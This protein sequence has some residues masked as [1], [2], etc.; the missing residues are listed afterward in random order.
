[1]QLMAERGLEHR[2]TPGFGWIKGEIAAM[3]VPGLRLPQ[4]GWNTLDFRPGAHPLLDGLVPGDHAYFV[5]SYALTG[6]DPARGARHHRLRRPGGR[7]GRRRQPRRHPVPCREKPGG[8]PAHPDQ[9]PAL[10]P[11]TMARSRRTDL[12]P[13]SLRAVERA[14]SLR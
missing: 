7:H 10:D 5:H 12:P 6:A 9:L 13:E 4:M 1:M 11:V 2:V 3:D 8:R 14:E